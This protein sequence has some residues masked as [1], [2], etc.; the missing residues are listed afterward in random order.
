ML[1][2]VLQKRKSAVTTGV[3]GLAFSQD[4]ILEFELLLLGG[5]QNMQ[6]SCHAYRKMSH[7]IKAG[8]QICKK[9]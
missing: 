7:F 4:E 6:K 3:A 8:I 1:R 2:G 5:E 9:A